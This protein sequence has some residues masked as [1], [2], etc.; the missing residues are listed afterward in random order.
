MVLTLKAGLSG[1]RLV[2]KM[3]QHC[4]QA[5]KHEA[6][7]CMQHQHIMA[8][9]VATYSHKHRPCTYVIIPCRQ[10]L[11]PAGKTLRERL[12][13]HVSMTQSTCNKFATLQQRYQQVITLRAAGGSTQQQQQQHWMQAAPQLLTVTVQG[14]VLSKAH[15]NTGCYIRPQE[16]PR[17]RKLLAGERSACC[18]A[19]CTC[20]RPA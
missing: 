10:V 2:L 14:A 12:P 4:M 1:H 7:T 19:A 5:C 8:D 16:L 6:V 20:F 11:P 15:I 9:S 18:Q 13:L 17:A 3:Q